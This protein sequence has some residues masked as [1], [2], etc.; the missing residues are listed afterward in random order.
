MNVQEVFTELA[1]HMV[2][3]LMVHDQ[4][5]DYYSFLGL[6]GYRMEHEHQYLSESKA[7][8]DLCYYYVSH[9]DALLPLGKAEDPQI[10][11]S[12]WY[13]YTRFDVDTNTKRNGVQEG[14]DT[15]RN[16][17]TDS[18]RLYGELAKNLYDLGEISAY[19]FVTS[20]VQMVDAELQEVVNTT[21]LLS[22][23]NYDMTYISEVQ[24]KLMEKH[25]D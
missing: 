4:L 10:I 8:R 11:P 16:W 25:K 24:E 3:G 2:R 6:E 22:G 12:S 21:L 19:Q 5:A 7:F 14:F 15:W 17:E 23:T 18:R 1:S 20:L 13:K 9:Y